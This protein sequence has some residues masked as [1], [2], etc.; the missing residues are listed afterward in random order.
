[1]STVVVDAPLNRGAVARTQV[2]VVDTQ[3]TR[4]RVS[5]LTVEVE[6]TVSSDVVQVFRLR[7][8]K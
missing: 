3:L 8:K 6:R 4:G 7:K 1:M 2:I 5:S